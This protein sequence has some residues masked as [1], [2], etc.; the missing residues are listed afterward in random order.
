[1]DPHRDG[2]RFVVASDQK[3]DYVRGT[4]KGNTRLRGEVDY[5]TAAQE[6]RAA[7]QLDGVFGS[8]VG[9]SQITLTFGVALWQSRARAKSV[10]RLPQELHL[11]LFPQG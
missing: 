10:R 8:R 7:G 3:Y 9:D 1:M 5:V 4:A 6:F 2:K 11:T